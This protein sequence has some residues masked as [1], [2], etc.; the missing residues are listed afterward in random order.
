LRLTRRQ[1]AK[2]ALAASAAASLAV[3]FSACSVS[4]KAAGASLSAVPDASRSLQTDG[5]SPISFPKNFFWG[6]ATAAYQ[7]EGAWLAEGKGESIWDRF[8]HTSGKIRNGDTGDIACDSYHRWREDIALMRAMNLNSYRFSISWPR[9][10]PAG[11]G[12][13][14]AKGID[15]YDRLVDALLEA[16]IRPFVTLYHW[17]LPQALEDAGGWPDRDTASRFADY[18]EL[19]AH[20]L[21]DRVS[22]WTLFNEP[23]AFTYRGYLEGSHAPGRRSLLDFLRASHT[24]NLAQG[25]GFRALKAVRP[26]ARVGTA[27]SMSPCEPATDSEPDKLAAERAHAVTNLWFLE[28][29]LHSRYPAALSFLPETVMRIKPADFER[30]RA[31]LDFIGINL[32]YRTIASAPGILERISNTQ[33]WLFPVKMAAGEQGP[34]TDIGWEVWPQA[35]YDMIMRIT[36]DYSRPQ[37]EVS[38]SGCAYNDGP[39]AGGAVR[40]IRRVQYHRQYLRAVARAIADGAN[41]RGY[42]AWS[43]MDN[44]EWAEGYSQ[45]FGLAYLDF[46]TQQRTLKA[47]GRWYAD[48]AA[49]NRLPP[50]EKDP[51]LRSEPA[52]SERREP[53][54]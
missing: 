14:N 16:H 54:G 4:S 32:Y 42:H 8:A 45:R 46:K 43:L 23:L 6:T 3:D 10:Q 11:S 31:P 24:V 41:V 36:R 29:A 35:M 15:Y 5:A 18:V 38:E 50:L 1:F 53:M 34:R 47:S 12:L 19:V 37:I 52:M 21:G 9:I 49:E 33:L 7:I 48:A 40:D 30:M 25:A 20:S 28:T 22:D 2:S 26:S 39:D 27:F 17:D 51:S 44:F 13:A